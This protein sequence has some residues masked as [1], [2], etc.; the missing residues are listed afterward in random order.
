MA[1]NTMVSASD[2]VKARGQAYIQADGR[3][4]VSSRDGTPPHVKYYKAS[5]YTFYP[6]GQNV[7]SD[8]PTSELEYLTIDTQSMRDMEIVDEKVPRRGF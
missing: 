6:A 4:V 2:V 5:Y 7:V 1:L 3:L 8:I